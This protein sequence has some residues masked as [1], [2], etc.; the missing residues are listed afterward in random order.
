VSRG[1][2]TTEGGSREEIEG[3]GGTTEETRGGR[4]LL[5]RSG[6][7]DGGCAGAKEELVEEDESG[8][9]GISSVRGGDELD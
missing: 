4:R 7:T 1:G 5:S 6:L 3:R 2:Q 8:T 9:L